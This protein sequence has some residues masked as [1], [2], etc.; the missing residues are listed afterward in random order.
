MCAVGVSLTSV[1]RGSQVQWLFAWVLRSALQGLPLSPSVTPYIYPWGVPQ[2]ALR[3]VLSRLGTSCPRIAGV[4]RPLS[5]R[6]CLG[7]P[8]PTPGLVCPWMPVEMMV[9]GWKLRMS[10]MAGSGWSGWMVEASRLDTP[11]AVALS[12][13]SRFGGVSLELTLVLRCAVG[14]S[15]WSAGACFVSIYGARPRSIDSHRRVVS[16]SRGRAGL[17]LE[18]SGFEM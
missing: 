17:I 3:V 6:A 1:E 16:L 14:A 4:R 12:A 9:R 8:R 10:W 18:S 11:R 7:G 2:K 5:H 13:L 15:S